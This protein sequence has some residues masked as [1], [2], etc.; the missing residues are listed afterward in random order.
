[1]GNSRQSAIPSSDPGSTGDF[2]PSRRNSCLGGFRQERQPLSDDVHSAIASVVAS[3]A[4]MDRHLDTAIAHLLLGKEATARFLLKTLDHDQL[5]RLYQALLCD[6]FPDSE[7]QIT[8][9]I[10]LI[11]ELRKATEDM[12]DWLWSK[13]E[14]EATS[15]DVAMGSFRASHTKYQTVEAISVVADGLTR[16]IGFMTGWMERVDMKHRKSSRQALQLVS[17]NP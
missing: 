14:A 5:P 4:L 12:L 8:D 7:R 6:E 15:S 17:Q 9:L 2:E 3:S 1:M 11:E 13:T 10:G 16:V